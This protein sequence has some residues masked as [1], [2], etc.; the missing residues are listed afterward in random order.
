M[1]KKRTAEEQ[2]FEDACREWN[3][4]QSHLSAISG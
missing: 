3:G 4:M 1:C 2:T